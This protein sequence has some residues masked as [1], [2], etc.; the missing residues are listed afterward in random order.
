MLNHH[1]VHL[2]RL[3]IKLKKIKILKNLCVSKDTIN[4]VKGN[5][6]NGRKYLRITYPVRNLYVEYMK[7]AYN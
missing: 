6:G 4:R 1:I 5:P 3:S 2:I 7:N